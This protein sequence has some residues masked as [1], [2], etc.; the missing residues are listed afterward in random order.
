MKFFVF[1]GTTGVGKT[2][3]IRRLVRAIPSCKYVTPY[4]NRPP[5]EGENER[6]SV[7]REEFDRMEKAH[8]F[9]VVN[10]L[11]G[12]KYG[13]PEGLIDGILNEGNTPLLDFP[14]KH[15]DKLK[16]WKTFCYYVLPSSYEEI[17]RRLAERGQKERIEAA[18]AE[19]R[20][21]LR[22]G[23]KSYSSF[24][25]KIILNDDVERVLVETI[26]D[27]KTSS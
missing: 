22:D 25:D 10:Q 23:F 21:F 24:I 1:C 6:I 4:I 7:T 20:W 11:Y 19:I 12:N 5:R 15:I 8:K 18:I 2:T 17:K 27:I 16:P 26:E 13:T 14:L 3:I 9:T